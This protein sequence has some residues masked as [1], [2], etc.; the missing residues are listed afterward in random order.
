MD[1]FVPERIVAYVSQ[2]DL[3]SGELTVR[4][5]LDF[6][7]KCQGVGDSNGNYLVNS[8][9][10]LFYLP[11]VPRYIPSNVLE[12]NLTWSLKHSFDHYFLLNVNDHPNKLMFLR[13][14]HS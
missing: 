10:I 11:L 5:T 4:E 13:T 14:E 1:E 9:S 6:S 7:A 3:H 12:N 8:C 2:D